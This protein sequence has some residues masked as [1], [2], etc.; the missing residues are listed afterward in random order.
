MNT[1]TPLSKKEEIVAVAVPLL[2]KLLS[3]QENPQ[4]PLI[5]MVGVRVSDFICS[6][7]AAVYEGESQTDTSGLFFF[8]FYISISVSVPNPPRNTFD[9]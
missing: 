7:P 3:T 4:N 1:E 8:V 6:D 2:E 5:R 9:S